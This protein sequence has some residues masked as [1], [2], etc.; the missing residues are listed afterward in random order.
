[1]DGADDRAVS[2]VSFFPTGSSG[3]IIITSRNKEV[4]NLAKPYHLELREMPEGEALALLQKAARIEGPLSPEELESAK[5][6]IEKC[7]YLPGSIVQAGKYCHEL[8][9]TIRGEFHPYTFTQY[10]DL[11]FPGSK[12]GSKAS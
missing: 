6:L 5:T 12:P 10:L 4:S 8:S 2:L 7:N 11:F 3:T 9:G 1:M